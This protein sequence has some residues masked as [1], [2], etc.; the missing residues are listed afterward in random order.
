[1]LTANPE[2][3]SSCAFFC[4]N[5]LKLK[6]TLRKYFNCNWTMENHSISHTRGYANF[7]MS[8]ILEMPTVL[9]MPETKTF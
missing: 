1:M 7:Y 5:I 8:K 4:K 6:L 9:W 2:C 3:I